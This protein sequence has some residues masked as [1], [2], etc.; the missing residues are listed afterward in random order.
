M[1]LSELIIEAL[2]VIGGLEEGGC[3]KGQKMVFG[4]CRDV[5]NPEG[6]HALRLG[7]GQVASRSTG[8]TAG[9][10]TSKTYQRAL[11]AKL[12]AR[13]GKD[14]DA[15]IADSEK[16]MDSAE[17]S[18]KALRLRKST[19]AEF[20]KAIRGA[21]RET[22]LSDA[23]VQAMF[24]DKEPRRPSAR[25]RRKKTRVFVAPKKKFGSRY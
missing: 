17:D 7:K 15:K 10:Y 16:D 22:E 4:M 9:D 24:R 19:E 6:G 23:E 13:K 2:D 14:V 20:D 8:S 3:P 5:Y 25:A 12:Q 21:S 11:K 1:K 18:G